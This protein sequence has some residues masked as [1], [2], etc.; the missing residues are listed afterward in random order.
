MLSARPADALPFGVVS[1]AGFAGLWP[2][3]VDWQERV[4]RLLQR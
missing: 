1:L 3:R 4:G 2:R